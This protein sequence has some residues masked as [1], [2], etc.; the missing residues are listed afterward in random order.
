MIRNLR[1]EI[2]TRSRLR[3]KFCKNPTK[4]NEKLSKKERS[5]CV[6]LMRKC[7]KEYFHNI[8]NNSTVANENF[9]NFTRPSLVNKG[10]LNNNEIMLRK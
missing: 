3:N 1:K 2:Y 6:A 9:W 10:L 4:E 7:I 8:S 5:K